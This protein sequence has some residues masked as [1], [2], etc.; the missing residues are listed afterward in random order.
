VPNEILGIDLSE[1]RPNLND[2]DF[3]KLQDKG[4][5]F[6][7]TRLT[8]DSDYVDPSAKRYV[9]MA[10]SRGLVTGVYHFLKPNLDND[11]D[12]FGSGA[13][14]AQ[15]FLNALE[16]LDDKPDFLWLDV[17]QAG[18]KWSQISQFVERVR[19]ATGGCIG[20]YTRETFYEPRFGD[21]PAIFDYTWYARYTEDTRWLANWATPSEEESKRPDADFWQFTDDFR[22]QSEDGRESVDGNVANYATLK[23]LMQLAN[24]E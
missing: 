23:Q 16:D 13:A 6:V 15:N 5:G 18:V 22:W 21:K 24:I 12:G 11:L 20:L 17:E 4:L 10:E 19:S 7:F 9:R 14:Q 2:E 8:L 3:D 1:Y